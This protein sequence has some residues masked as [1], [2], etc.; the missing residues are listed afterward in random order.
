MLIVILITHTATGLSV[1][2]LGTLAASVFLLSCYCFPLT[3]TMSLAGHLCASHAHRPS[4]YDAYQHITLTAPANGPPQVFDVVG[5]VC[6]S[7]DFL[8]KDRQLATPR[9][10]SAPSQFP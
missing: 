1:C 6:E 8:G 4:L 9:E 2:H 5:P 7:A 10:F 3:H